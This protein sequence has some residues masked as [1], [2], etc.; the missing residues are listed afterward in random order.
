MKKNIFVFL[1]NGFSDWEIAY[2]TPEIYKNQS[3]DLVYFSKDGDAVISLGGLEIKP[4]MALSDLK[5]DG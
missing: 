5:V 3:F 4:N 2:L 1:F